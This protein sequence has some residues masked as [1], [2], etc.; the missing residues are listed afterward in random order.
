MATEAERTCRM[1]YDTVH[2][3]YVCT[4]CGEVFEVVSYASP[5]L[6][7]MSCEWVESVTYKKF[8]YCPCCGAKVEE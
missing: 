3:D 1:E 8:K 2:R 5:W 7:W 6:N 4:E